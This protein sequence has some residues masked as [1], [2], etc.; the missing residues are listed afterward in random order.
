M[1]VEVLR[2]RSDEEARQHLKDLKTRFGNP[3][4]QVNLEAGESERQTDVHL[5]VV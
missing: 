3:Q 2:C 1:R 4:P 5:V